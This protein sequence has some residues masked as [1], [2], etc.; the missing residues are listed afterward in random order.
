MQT[1]N[2]YCLKLTGIFSVSYGQ[3]NEVVIKLLIFYSCLCDETDLGH[4]SGN[5]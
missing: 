5:S 1:Q 2:S 3:E 4:N